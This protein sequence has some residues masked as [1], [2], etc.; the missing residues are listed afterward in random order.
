MACPSK[1]DAQASEQAP[2]PNEQ[3]GARY[4]S[5]TSQSTNPSKPPFGS[6]MLAVRN[7]RRPERSGRPF[8]GDS[9]SPT[10]RRNGPNYRP[11]PPAQFREK[12]ASNITASIPVPPSQPTGS[13][14]QV[15]SDIQDMEEEPSD[16]AEASTQQSPTTGPSNRPAAHKKTPT[17]SNAPVPHSVT[18]SSLDLAADIRPINSQ[19]G[20]EHQGVRVRIASQKSTADKTLNDI[21]NLL[22]TNAAHFKPKSAGPDSAHNSQDREHNRGPPSTNDPQKANQKDPLYHFSYPAHQSGPVK[23]GSASSSGCP[24]DPNILNSSFAALD[25]NSSPHSSIPP[26]STGEAKDVGAQVDSV[27]GSSQCMEEDG[28]ALGSNGFDSPSPSPCPSD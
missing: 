15:L 20:V 13:R 10:V 12:G 7:R 4:Q 18:I 16:P 19:T 8:S 25:P 3:D 26:L 21:T 9:S 28:S 27:E 5:S 6:W 24:P 22:H 23:F 11:P 17:K 2:S 1:R 14:F